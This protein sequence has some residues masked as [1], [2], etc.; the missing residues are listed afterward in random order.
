M[1]PTKMVLALMFYAG[2]KDRAST[3]ISFLRSK[4][5]KQRIYVST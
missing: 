4:Y 5:A 1:H 2:Y 3:D